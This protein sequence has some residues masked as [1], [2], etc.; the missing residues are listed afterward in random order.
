MRPS[1]TI[2][3]E[4]EYQTIDPRPLICAR[5]SSRDGGEGQAGPER[6]RQ[7]RD[8]PVGGGGRDRHLRDHQGGAR[9]I[10]A[11]CARQ[12][13]QLTQENG[14][15]LVAGRDPPL[16]RLA[17]AGHLSRRRAT[18]MV[19]DLQKVARAN[20]IFGLHV[21]VGH[22]RP[23]SRACALDEPDALL[24]A[25]PPRPLD[26]LAVLDW[27]EHGLKS[28]RCKVFDRFPRTNIPDSVRATA[29][30]E[31]FVNLL[32]RP[33]ASTTRRRSGGTS[34]RT[35]SSTPSRCGYATSRCALEET[36]AIAALIQAT[37][38]QALS[39]ARAATR[40]G[41]STLARCSW[42]TSGA[43]SATGSTAS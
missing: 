3:I 9:E 19:E 13:L 21:H 8:A 32:V 27:H 42:R 25:P 15:H 33:S 4:E 24:P 16:C 28:Y 34:A 22:R 11:T 23:R 29:D 12:M 35:H 10:C 20:L 1:F 38:G 2:G 36:L 17:R 40:A 14:L 43:P 31:N 39:P 6:A 41:G 37:G 5:T 30:F 18:Q 7:G 26:E